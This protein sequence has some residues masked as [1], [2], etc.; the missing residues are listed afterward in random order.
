MTVNTAETCLDPQ[1]RADVRSHGSNGIDYVEVSEHQPTLTV[2]FL[3]K[4]PENLEKENVLIEAGPKGRKVRVLEVRLCSVDDPEQDDCM[5][6][7]LDRRGD[8]TT[9]TLRLVE[10]DAQG[11]P[12]ETPLAGLDPRYAQLDFRFDTEVTS[13]IDCKQPQVCVPTQLPPP[14]INYLAKDYASF[15]QLI[16]DR[17]ALI[18]PDWQEQHVPDEGVALAEI[19]AYTADYLSYYQDAVATEAYLSTARQRISVRRHVRLLDYAMHEGCNARA[20]VILNTSQKGSLDPG[21]IYF[22]AGYEGLALGTVL[23]STD[24]TKVPSGSYLVFEP[25]AT[26]SIDLYPAHNQISFYT[27]GDQHCCLP[28]GATSATLLDGWE[29]AA[30]APPQPAGRR[31]RA[32]AASSAPTSAP[33]EP[34]DP[35]RLVAPRTRVLQL[36]PGDLL[37]LKEVIGPESGS[38]DD[39]DPNHQQVVRLTK[40]TTTCF[41]SLYDPPVPVVEVEWA[42]QDALTFDLCL[43]TIGPAAQGCLLLPDVSIA[44]GNVIMVDEGSW[45]RNETLGTVPLAAVQQLCARV[46]HPADVQIA[47]GP[48]RPTLQKTPIT[49]RQSPDPA[50][51]AAGSL[52]QDARL[53]LPQIQLRSIPP[54]P[55]GS[56]P[57]FSPVELA[58]PQRLAARVANPVDEATQWL[59]ERFSQKT[60]ALLKAFD[61]KQPIKLALVQALDQEMG[62]LIRAW[63]PQPDLLESQADDYNYVV[64]IDDSGIAHLRFGD[65]ELGRAVEAGETFFADYRIGSGPDGNVGAGAIQHL[66]FVNPDNNGHN[67]VIGLSVTP[68]NPLPAQGGT[69][70]ESVDEVKLFAPGTFLTTLQRAITADD[71]AAIAERNP[72]LQRAAA[73]LLWTGTCYEAHVAIDP[74]GTETVD[75]NLIQEIQDYLYRFRRIGHDLVVVPAQYVPL[76]LAMTVDVL[77]DYI[78]GHVRAALLD[79]FSDRVLAGGGRGFFH[80]D[81]LSFG[82]NIYLSQLVATAQA[83]TGVHSVTVAKLERLYA[84]SNHELETGFLAIGPLEVAQ[85]D[86]DPALPERGKLLLTLRG[87]L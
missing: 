66:G 1:R 44:C 30:A 23:S 53:A 18:M 36:K 11:N 38:P 70:P 16:F 7:L 80:P 71:Y 15:L 41:D 63:T 10:L 65:G 24:L 5:L 26:G 79:A 82:D 22:I 68:S 12:I 32:A 42:V 50:Q 8:L 13:D 61:P 55:D 28:R 73:T 69:A 77:P 75:A 21:S 74:L 87:G 83:V 86:N 20:W 58:N 2:Y 17:L 57:L 60:I 64:E 43:S 14:D 72:K 85:L 4:A 48:F 29:Q 35:A 39:A 37:L 31:R 34:N 51:V 45:I 54:L 9:C 49:F 27:W 46:N 52:N 47:P 33:S 56:G 40:V 84:G 78:A 3:R 62:S 6:V 67:K 19:L 81:N 25:T 59:V 76:D